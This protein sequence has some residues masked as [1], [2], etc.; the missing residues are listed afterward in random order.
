[1][2]FDD[3][4]G[5]SYVE[6]LYGSDASQDVHDPAYRIERYTR[7]KEQVEALGFASAAP[8]SQPQAPPTGQSEVIDTIEAACSQCGTTCQTNFFKTEIPYFKEIILIA[9][10]CDG[11]GYR[12]NEVKS[13]GELSEKGKRITLQLSDEEDLSRYIL[14]SETC[15]MIIPE[16][17][18]E[19]MQGTLGGKFTTVEGLLVD[20]QDEFKQKIPFASGDSK[21]PMAPNPFELTIKELEEVIFGLFA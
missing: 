18:L 1:M 5:N 19:V 9:T 20:L 11:C 12:S 21:D 3:P 10:V 8:A 6:E 4:S 7:T 2:I 14:K 17:E 15:T 16:I 13:F